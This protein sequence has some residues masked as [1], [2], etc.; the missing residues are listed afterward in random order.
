[1]RIADWYDQSTL[2]TE[3]AAS[4]RDAILI[5]VLLAALVLFIFLRSLKITLVAMMTVPAALATTVLLLNV[6]GDSFN[7][8]TLGGM[9]AALSLT[10]ASVLMVSFLLA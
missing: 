4:V 6:L 7:I 1:M 5:G 8:M 3:S 9:A 2:V 10:M